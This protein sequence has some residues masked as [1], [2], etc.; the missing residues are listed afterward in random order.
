[1]TGPRS[2][3]MA[4][5]HAASTRRQALVYKLPKNADAAQGFAAMD[6]AFHVHLG[7]L[8]T[9]SRAN[10]VPSAAEALGAIMRGCEGCHAAYRADH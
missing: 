5:A 8:V 7:A 2:A 4:S 1:M 6:E 10:D 9:A 3:N